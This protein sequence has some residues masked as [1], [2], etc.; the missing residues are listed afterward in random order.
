V[1]KVMKNNNFFKE[2]KWIEGLK[3][4]SRTSCYLNNKYQINTLI[5]II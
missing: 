4:R 1:Q 5:K 2:Q 3:R